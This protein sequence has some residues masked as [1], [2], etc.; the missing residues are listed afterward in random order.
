MS[1]ADA[2]RGISSRQLEREMRG[3]WFDSRHSRRL[4]D[5]APS[6]YKDVL[7]VM[8]AQ[9]ELTRIERQLEPILSY[10]GH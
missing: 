6:A 8:R 5:E 4:C 7:A 10:K 9:R 3:V 2:A 1:R